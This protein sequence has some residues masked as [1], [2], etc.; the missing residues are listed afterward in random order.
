MEPSEELKT[1]AAI[2]ADWASPIPTATLYLYGSRVR[3]DHRPDSDVDV[4]VR[5]TKYTDAEVGWWTENN[6][7]EFASINSKLPGPLQILEQDDPI[8]LQVYAAPEVY[9][10]RNVRCVWRAPKPTHPTL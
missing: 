3:G 5:F 2:L 8:T 10:D 4:S 9:R 7:E 6:Q 1:L